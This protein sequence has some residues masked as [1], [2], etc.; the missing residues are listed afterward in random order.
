MA[1][2]FAEVNDRVNK[3]AREMVS[4]DP[5]DF[6]AAH[7]VKLRSSI[8]EL[9]YEVY[10]KSPELRDEYGNET[11]P[12]GLTRTK[13]PYDVFFDA[14]CALLERKKNGQWA[15]DPT[16][17]S[18]VTAFRDRLKY[19]HINYRKYSHID[20]R[21]MNDVQPIHNP[22]RFS[23]LDTEDILAEKLEDTAIRRMVDFAQIINDWA[24][25]VQTEQTKNKRIAE[26]CRGAFTFDTTKEIKSDKQQ[27]EDAYKLNNALF[28]QLLLLMLEYLM[29][30]D[31]SHIIDVATNPLR[32]GVDLN[33][34]G[35]LLKDF[36]H[37]SRPTRVSY[38]KKYN[39]FRSAV[40]GTFVS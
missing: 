22:V 27:A 31:F 33:K 4:H 37:I 17:G 18:F 2:D 15:Y 10:I 29:T 26:F 14:L 20:Y 13:V 24:K 7:V 8:M 39:S 12:F 5:A 23:S 19:K 34:R 35:D 1:M 36:F 21:N 38:D 6:Y 28:P 9:L 25:M 40:L 3:M 30:G 16:K 11:R 32:D